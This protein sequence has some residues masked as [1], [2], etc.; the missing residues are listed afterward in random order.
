[1]ALALWM[2]IGIAAIAF[3]LAL[4]KSRDLMVFLNV[5]KKN[6]FYIMFFALAFFVAFSLY[7][8]T[9]NHGLN[10]GSFEGIV[11]AGKLY[12]L[13]LKSIVVNMGKITGYAVNQDWVL[14]VTNISK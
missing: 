6:F 13:W 1:M 14:N 12:F 9:K 3:F 8:V 4:F 5:V 2:V 11:S 7:Q 10:F